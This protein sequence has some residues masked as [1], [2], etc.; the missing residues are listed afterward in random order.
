MPRWYS[1]ASE[2]KL[3]ELVGA[4]G[5]TIGVIIAGTIF[6][7]FVTTKYIELYK[8]YVELAAEYR[9]VAGEHTRHDPLREQIKGYRRRLV[10]LNRASCL[11]AIAL[12]SFLVAVASGGLSLIYPPVRAIKAVGTAGLGAGILLIAAAVTLELIESYKARAEIWHE[13]RDLDEETTRWA[14]RR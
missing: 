11:A 10:L 5:A 4:A 7:Q 6:L 13:I 12:L 1:Q 14:P 2:F 8:R 9:G 3:T